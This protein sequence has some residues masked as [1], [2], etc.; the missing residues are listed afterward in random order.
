[1]DDAFCDV[2]PEDEEAVKPSR[3]S[4]S[5]RENERRDTGKDRYSEE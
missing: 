1:M 2:E 4:R 5:L 3:G